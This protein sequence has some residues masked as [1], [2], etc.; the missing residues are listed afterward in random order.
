[1]DLSGSARRHDRRRD[2]GVESNARLT[3]ATGLLLL[4]MLA[5]EGFTI[6]SIHPLLAWHIAI[7]LAL[8]PPVAVKLGST[9]WRFSR[10]YL[11]DARYRQA[12]PP[13]PILRIL[14]P[15]VVLTTAAVLASGVAVWVAGPDHSTILFLHKASFVLWAGAMTIHVLGHITRAAKLAAADVDASSRAPYRGTRWGLVGLSLVAGIVVAVTTRG[16]ATGW[17]GHF[18]HG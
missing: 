17:S 15:F 1:M 2:P 14:G 4:V 11:R 8:I 12:G 13:H 16:L 18:H 5:G 10:Y 7:G 6:L 9:T 3:A